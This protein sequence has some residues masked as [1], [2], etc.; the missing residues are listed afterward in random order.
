MTVN[1]AVRRPAIYETHGESNLADVLDLAGG[2]LPTAALTNIQVQRLIAHESRTMLSLNVSNQQDANAVTQQLAAFKVEPGDVIQIFPIAPFNRDAV[3]LQ[4]HAVRPGRYSYHKEM[5]LSELVSSYSDLLPEPALNYAE[6][7]RLTPPAYAPTVF[8]FN[9]ADVLAKPA[10]SPLLQPL[11]TVRIFGRYDFE[12]APMVT[13]TGA[14]RRPGTYKTAGMI[15]VSDAV[16]LGGNLT[17]DASAEDA[18]VVHHQPDGSIQ[19]MNVDLRKAEAGDPA[20]NLLLAPGDRVLVHENQARS[21]PATV[22]VAGEVANP[23]RYPLTAALRVSDLIRISGGLK[24]SA[25]TSSAD[26]VHYLPVSQGQQSTSHD[27]IRMDAALSGQPAD[28]MVLR[29][30]DVLTI[31]R[32]TGWDD[33]GASITLAGEVQHPGT[34]GFQP[35]ERLSS[36][37]KRAG[38]FSANAYPYGAVLVRTDVREMQELN[39]A[40]MVRRLQSEEQQLKLMPEGD[41]E[42]KK[43]KEVVLQQVQTTVTNLVNNAALGRVV[44]H[45]TDKVDHWANTS[46][47]IQ[48]RAGDRLVVPKRMESVSVIGQVYNT[49]A[50]AYRRGKNA[51][52]Y[53]GQAGG[54]TNL[55]NRKAVFV[56]RA[57]GSVIGGQKNSFLSG[58]PLK[59]TLAP[60]DTVVVPEK[61]FTTNHNLQNAL[62]M[63][64]IA[65]AVA[66]IGYF[67]SITLP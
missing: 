38:G 18:Q 53:L 56:L 12:D 5:R 35:G 28:D 55:G 6:I 40:E 27:M 43:T 62:L 66:S 19:V 32:L 2:M 17:T 9:L 16:H 13:V 33:V 26:L 36:V 41:P 4:G 39:R 29:D 50:V 49:T 59:T 34:Y 24:R 61:A 63:A 65:S 47:D 44:I 1:G 45:I 15:H 67:A 30:G 23:G 14:V 11:D 31:R 8:S 46:N 21:N 58:N 64:Q 42:Q 48:L 54:A 60:G 22:T 52:W 10:S 57:D 25:D 3:Y 51:E 37:L 7:I 20:N